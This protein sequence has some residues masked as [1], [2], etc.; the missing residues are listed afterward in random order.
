MSIIVDCGSARKERKRKKK[1]KEKKKKRKQKRKEDTPRE[2]I[3]TRFS[4][5]H[6]AVNT[7]QRPLTSKRA[8][9]IMPSG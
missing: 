3:N 9:R 7:Q 4:M 2:N 6:I 5:R 8:L 1:K